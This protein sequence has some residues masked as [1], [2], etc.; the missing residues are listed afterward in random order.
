MRKKVLPC[1]LLTAFLITA[2]A[3]V[4]A[5]FAQGA[6][7]QPADSVVVYYF[8]GNF[9]CENCHNMERWTKELVDTAFKDQAAAG[10]L[11]FRMLNTDEKENRHYLDDYKLYTKSVVLSLVRGGKEARYDNLAKVWDYLRS[12]RKFQE[13]VGREIEKYL[14]EL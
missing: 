2:V 5:G 12:K 11:I 13:Y 1:A 7:K 3:G 8:H 4:S 10:K 9:R 6:E 14:K